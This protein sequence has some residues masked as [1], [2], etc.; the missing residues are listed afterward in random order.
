[1]WPQRVAACQH[2]QVLQHDR[3]EERRHQLVGRRAFLLQAVDVRFREDAA[4]AGNL[5]QLDPVVPLVAQLDGR[6][7][8]LGVDLVD[9]RAGPAG[10]FVVHRGNLLLASGLR[11]L[12]EDDDLGVLAA[13]LDDRVHFG[14]EFLDRQRDG[15]NLL[16][17]LGAD[18][19][20]NRAAAGSGDEHPA[21]RV[22]DPEIR[23]EAAEKFER[24]FG[25]LGLVPLV[26]RP[27]H[28]VRRGIDRDGLDRGRPDVDADEQWR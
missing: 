12:L 4:L 2:R 16:H 7:L 21:G 1:M 27:E 15:G 13:K 17:E 24:F 23:L 20:R 25:L 5:V 3:V 10:A 18:E 19:R 9:D 8:Q 14:M 26:V 22:G 28:R 11:I 6:D